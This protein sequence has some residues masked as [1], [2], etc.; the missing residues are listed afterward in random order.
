MKQ[1]KYLLRGKKSKVHL[2]RQVGGLRE[3]E[4]LSRALGTVWITFK[5]YFFWLF[6]G[7]SFRFVWFTV[8]IWYNLRILPC[9]RAHLLAKMDFTEKVAGQSILW[10][11][12]P[13]DLQGGFCAHV[14]SGRSS[15]FNNEKYVVWAGSAFCLNCLD[16]LV[17]GFQSI[18]NESPIAVPWVGG[19]SASCLKSP[20]RDVNPKKLYWEDE[21]GRSVFCNFLRLTMEL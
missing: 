14:W 8:H 17:L 2:D 1:V 3:R 18:E 10:H 19:P 12:F 4:L 21:R 15:D 9:V 11:C 6:F 7:Q 5:G 16:I 13:F 20:L